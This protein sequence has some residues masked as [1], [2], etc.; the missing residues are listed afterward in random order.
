MMASPIPSTARAVWIPCSQRSP[1]RSEPAKAAA[2]S[3]V[4]AGEAPK[5]LYAIR[6]PPNAEKNKKI[7]AAEENKSN[8]ACEVMFQFRSGISEARKSRTSTGAKNAQGNSHT[9]CA[10]HHSPSGT[11]L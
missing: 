7:N 3:K 6:D 5:L 10:A 11:A 8:R 2:S 9:K 1:A 4:I